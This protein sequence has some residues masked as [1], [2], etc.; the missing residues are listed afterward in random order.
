ML[1][2]C[3]IIL[4]ALFA[5]TATSAKAQKIA[6][7]DM[8]QLVTSMP[9]AKQAYDTL[10]KYQQEMEKDGQAL[11]AEFQSKLDVFNK[12][13]PTMSAN[14]KEI[15]HKELEDAQANIQD[16]KNR[17][18]QKLAAKEQEL[19][20]PIVAKAKKA[21]NAVAT[22]K[23]IACVLDNSKE[24]IVTTTGEDLMPAVKMKLGLK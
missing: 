8:Q 11:V 9:E 15:K 7:I 23:G 20:T 17:M 22:E 21:V 19:T 1:K 3:T 14:M 12:A 16:F 13:E 5:F 6:Y 4:L 10:Q 18:D 24:I 2:N